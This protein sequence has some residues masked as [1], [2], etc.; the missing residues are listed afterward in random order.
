[1]LWFRL[2]SRDVASGTHMLKHIHMLTHSPALPSRSFWGSHPIISVF[3][4]R[5]LGFCPKYLWEEIKIKK[6]KK[7]EKKNTQN[8]IIT[9]YNNYK[10]NQI[11]R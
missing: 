4:P 10:F 2:N 5:F 9:I 6:K 3:S 1:M 11:K 8:V 7:Q